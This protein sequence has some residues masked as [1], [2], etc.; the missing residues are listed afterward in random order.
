[1]IAVDHCHIEHPRNYTLES[2][3]LYRY[4]TDR[5]LDQLTKS[6]CELGLKVF[7]DGFNCLNI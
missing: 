3:E 2:R 5:S 1:M 4:G 7:I 6:Q